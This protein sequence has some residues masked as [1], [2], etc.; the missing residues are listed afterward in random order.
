MAEESSI[1]PPYQPDWVIVLITYNVHEAHIVAGRLIAEGVRAMVYQ[2]PGASALG[3]HIGRFG[4][5]KVLVRPQ[6]YEAAR[7]ILFVDELPHLA[8]DNTQIIF[9]ED[10]DADDE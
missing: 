3:I 1:S 10:G 8:A 9:D 4:E 2:E 7:S 6:D 5:I